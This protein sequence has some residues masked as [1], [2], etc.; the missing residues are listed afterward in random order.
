M[1]KQKTKH[2]VPRGYDFASR[3]S[4]TKKRADA[5]AAQGRKQGYQIKVYQGKTATG[6]KAWGLFA[7]LN[8]K[9]TGWA[10]KR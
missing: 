6:K 2:I 9:G 4:Y 7:K 10:K 8:S 5:R 1:V 3:Y